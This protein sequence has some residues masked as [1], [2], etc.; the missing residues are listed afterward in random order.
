MLDLNLYKTTGS[1]S[2]LNSFDR[3][4]QVWDS[5]FVDRINGDT[6]FALWEDGRIKDSTKAGPYKASY[7]NMEHALLNHLYTALWVNHHPVTVYF[8][9]EES[10]QGDKLYPLPI[11]GDKYQITKVWIDDK[12]YPGVR[13]GNLFIELPT[14]NN[15]RIKVELQSKKSD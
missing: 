15:A 12:P 4:A 13:E 14:L 2:Y 8:N 10:K 3:G 5:G 6:H 11:E 7:H 9:I 1:L